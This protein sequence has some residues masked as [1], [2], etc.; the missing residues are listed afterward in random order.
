MN[1]REQ[2]LRVLEEVFE[3]G[4]YSNIALNNELVKYELKP[5]DKALATRIVYGTIQYKIFLEYQL[6]PVIKTK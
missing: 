3:Q 5:A 4:A 2:I 6:K 1:A